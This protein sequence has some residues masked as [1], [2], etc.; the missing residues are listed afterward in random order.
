ML[1]RRALITGVRNLSPRHNCPP[2][3]SPTHCSA[4]RIA[5]RS[6]ARSFSRAAF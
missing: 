3:F 1:V 4:A 6:R 2:D 5:S